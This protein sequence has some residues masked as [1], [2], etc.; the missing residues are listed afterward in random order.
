MFTIPSNVPQLFHK[1][2]PSIPH[3]LKP[4]P[5]EQY[6]PAVADPAPISYPRWTPARLFLREAVPHPTFAGCDR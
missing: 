2:P 6:S 5:F 3:C 1:L 4:I